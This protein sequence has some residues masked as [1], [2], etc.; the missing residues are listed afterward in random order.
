MDDDLI[1]TAEAA[2][3]LGVTRRTLTCW[4][5]EGKVAATKDGGHLVAPHRYRRGDVVALAARI[6]TVPR[7]GPR[8]RPIWPTAPDDDLIGTTEAAAILG[9][10]ANALR[11]RAARGNVPHVR[12]DNGRVVLYW[13]RRADILALAA[14]IAAGRRRT[15]TRKVP[16][17]TDGL[18]GA[19][20]V[21]RMLGVSRVTVQNW[22]NRGAFPAIKYQVPGFPSVY[23]FEMAEVLAFVERSRIR[24]DGANGAVDPGPADG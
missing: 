17:P 21:A 1:G 6:G 4:V 8:H 14:D 10:N 2:T 13:F 15:S 7:S 16:D 5:R 3:I 23:R 18:V 19:A 22:V 24:P 20:E 11:R 12:E 9:Q